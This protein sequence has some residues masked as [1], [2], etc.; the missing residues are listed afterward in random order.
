MKPM[1]HLATPWI[2]ASALAAHAAFGSVNDDLA[3][4]FA[5][6][7][8][9]AYPQAVEALSRI[10]ADAQTQ[11]VVEYWKAL[12]QNRLQEF[13]KAAAGFKRAQQ[14]GAKFDD[15]QYEM[16]QA[17]FANQEFD[18]AKGAFLASAQQ[19]FKPAASQYYV[20][21]IHQL[22]EDYAGATAQYRKLLSL[23]DDAERIK[24]PALLQI[25]EIRLEQ[26]ESLKSDAAKRTRIKT[27]V[28]PV[29]RKVLAYNA[30][31]P[32]GMEAQSRVIELEERLGIKG[33]RPSWYARVT[34]E[35]KYDS[36]VITQ[37]EQAIVEVSKAGSFLQKVDAVAS[38][39]MPAGESF[40]FTPDFTAGYTIHLNR[41]TP[42]VY[43]NDNFTTTPALRMRFDHM[44]S[45]SLAS[46]L[47]DLEYNFTL[48]DY[49]QA[50]K[51][52]YY[53]RY[54]NVVVGERFKWLGS[55]STTVKG[56]FKLYGN[57]DDGQNSMNPGV[58]VIQTFTWERGIGASLLFSMDYNRARSA[59]NDRMTY[60]LAPV[61][62]M[63]RILLGAD[64]TASFDL[65]VTDNRNQRESRGIEKLI[66]P[67]LTAQW[68]FFR[69]W[70]ANVSYAFTKNYSLDTQNYAYQKHVSG[71][72]LSYRF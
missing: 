68:T 32:A 67:S 71:L 42:S 62:T 8:K 24:Q 27:S 64:V 3:R 36:N 12:C 44:I 25:A 23:P 55:G 37:A 63:P 15:L 31:T 2:L 14:L 39:E 16:G 28:L 69:N 45:D 9:G 5:L 54:S 47:L 6:Y 41:G 11:A 51:L 19:K 66:S 38:Y 26:A 13:D 46:A 33:A 18:L 72:G 52:M 57:Q 49:T 65:M 60:R 40:V 48:R 10:Q 21:Y 30:A 22:K 1:R 35:S 50:Q 29:Y 34:T 17:L 7:K 58:S 56:N 59:L 4:S 43:Q 20:A 61:V 53:S 70:Q